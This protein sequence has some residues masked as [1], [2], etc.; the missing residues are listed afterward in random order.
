MIHRYDD[1]EAEFF[2]VQK[3]GIRSFVEGF[4]G[5]EERRFFR[6]DAAVEGD[7]VFLGD[8]VKLPRR[9]FRFEDGR[10]F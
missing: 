6:D 2:I 8:W 3:R 10:E 1:F 9:I 4:L 5:A 7:R